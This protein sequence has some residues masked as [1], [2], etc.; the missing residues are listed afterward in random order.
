MLPVIAVETA[1]PPIETVPCQT[2]V[3]RIVENVGVGVAAD[4]DMK[5]VVF[6]SY[7]NRPSALNFNEKSVNWQP[8]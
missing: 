3:G 4:A 6:V 8:G 1:D 7:S 5:P 2:G